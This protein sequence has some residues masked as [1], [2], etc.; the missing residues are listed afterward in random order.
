LHVRREHGEDIVTSPERAPARWFQRVLPVS[1]LVVLLIALA[2]VVVP[3]FRDQLEL[4]LSRQPQPYVELYFARSVPAGGQAVCSRSGS[5][6]RVRFV[7]ASH[8]EHRQAVAYRVVVDPAAKGERTMRKGGSLRTAPGRA[9]GTRT[10]F[11]LPRRQGYT[12]SVTLPAL[13]QQVRA[14]CPGH[15]S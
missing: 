11:A 9:T 14:H 2:A 12:V 4:S 1:G 15:P 8:L 5:T 3:S 6:V 7:V 10:T 13:H